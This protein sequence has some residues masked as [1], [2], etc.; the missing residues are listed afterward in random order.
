M[1]KDKGVVEFAK[2]AGAIRASGEHD[3]WRFQLA[4]G[5]DDG[6]PAS[7]TEAELR[8]LE[9]DFG[10]EWLGHRDDVGE[11]LKRCHVFCLPSYYREG[12]PKV[13]LEASAVGRAM[14]ASDIAGCREVVTDDVTGVIVPTR[15]VG[16]LVKAMTRLGEDADLRHRLAVAA[17]EKAVAVFS[18]QD[19]VTHTFRVYEELCPVAGQ[20]A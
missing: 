15:D 11:L 18:E 2:A 10:V 3:D 4:G 14:I 5:V 1:L 9:T 7:L 8:K 19:V 16:S 6:N 12:V 13:L 17:H 20:P